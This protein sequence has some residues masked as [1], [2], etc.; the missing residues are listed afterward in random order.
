MTLGHIHATHART[1]ETLHTGKQRGA[2]AR[3]KL[4]VLVLR[5]KPIEID[6]PPTIAATPAKEQGTVGGAWVYSLVYKQ[7]TCLH[8]FGT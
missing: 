6:L 3:G 7:C 4:D 1:F 5:N 2:H 8:L